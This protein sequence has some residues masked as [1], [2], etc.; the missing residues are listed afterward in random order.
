ME[1]AERLHQEKLDEICKQSEREREH[2][3][4][5][6]QEKEAA[7]LKL[8]REEMQKLTDERAMNDK[9]VAHELESLR[10][11]ARS[12]LEAKDL[13]CK[14]LV[15]VAANVQADLVVEEKAADG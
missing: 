4:S 13:E 1:Q 7:N 14:R 11:Q 12:A 6:W 2:R 9:R 8:F 5:L 3:D 15:D 10:M